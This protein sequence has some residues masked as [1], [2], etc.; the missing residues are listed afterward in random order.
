MNKSTLD[1]T[2]YRYINHCSRIKV[3]AGKFTDKLPSSQANKE[4]VIRDIHIPIDL[5]GQVAT[6]AASDIPL[7]TKVIMIT[8]G[9][10]TEMEMYAG[11]DEPDLKKQEQV[12]RHISFC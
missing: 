6:V 11:P 5:S 7:P 4:V 8:D 2:S 3:E 1:L 12:H 10:P 9:H